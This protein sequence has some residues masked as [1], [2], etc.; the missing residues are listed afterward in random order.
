M[1][2]IRANGQA[3]IDIIVVVEIAIVDIARIIIVVTRRPKPEKKQETNE[4]LSFTMYDR[5]TGN[6]L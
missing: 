4:R 1:R 2:V 6:N 5:F 3:I